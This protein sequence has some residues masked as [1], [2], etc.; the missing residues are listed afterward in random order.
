MKKSDE[1]KSMESRKP[2]GG[3]GLRSNLDP[4]HN[5]RIEYGCSVMGYD[6][7]QGCKP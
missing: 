7:S 3:R 5:S 6:E 2:Q 1:P 4:L